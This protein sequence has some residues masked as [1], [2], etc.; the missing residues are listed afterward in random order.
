MGAFI[1][2]VKAT[3]HHG[4]SYAAARGDA[5]AGDV[6]IAWQA[7]DSGGHAAMD[8]AGD[9][10]A[11]DFYPGGSWPGEASGF[12]SG[13]KVW[14]RQAVTSE[15]SSY[16]AGQGVSADGVTLIAAVAG[17]DFASLRSD[18]NPGLTS[19][20]LTP[21]SASGIEFRFAAGVPAPPGTSVSF[22]HP[23]GTV[24]LADE[25]SDVW[26]AAGLAWAPIISTSPVG[27]AFWTGSNLV[28]SC[29]FTLLLAA[30]EDPSAPPPVVAP[31]AP[32]RGRATWRYRFMRMLTREYLGDLDL[33]G[34][35]LDKRILSPGVINA[36]VPIPSPRIADKV[37]EIIP[38][39][40][41]GDPDSYPLDRGPGAISVEVLRLGEPQGEYW[42][43]RTRLTRS[44][45]GTMAIALQGSTLEGYLG[46]VE[47]EDDLSYSADQADILRNLVNHLMAQDN[48]NISLEL[49]EGTTGVTREVTYPADGSTYLRRL[50]ELA[51]QD[52]GFEWMINLENIGGQLVRRLVW[53]YPTLGQAGGPHHQWGDGLYSG[54]I[55]E[56]SEEA[57]ALRGFT[58]VRARGNSISADAS[59]PSV[60]LISSAHEASAHLAAGWPRTSKTL[61]YNNQT[62]LDTLEAY[63]AFWAERAAGA[64]RVDMATV[65]YGRDVTFT[66]NHLGDLARIYL[67]NQWHQGVW[68]T[69]RVIGIGIT[70]V[71]KT[72]AEEAKLVFEGTEAP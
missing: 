55:L 44:R 7:A 62:D 67:R 40:A 41:A 19:P 3:T 66:P 33:V 9:W 26:V 47:I 17:A 11:V 50:V 72:G 13:V 59:T 43:H 61:S 57:D 30:A 51:Q 10:N 6:L 52:G 18:N 49:A 20:S 5:R 70:P 68:R 69:R 48:A 45:K 8:L 2:S 15:P 34:V 16:T 60:P 31:G 46:A 12:W 23:P 1:R 4:G 32:G 25:Q 36:T 56:L 53:G 39:E 21:G 71:T 42:I 58:R 14:A 27:P 28:A 22:S 38:R 65:A 64:I 37:A 24:E 29:A 35:D 54:D 63:A